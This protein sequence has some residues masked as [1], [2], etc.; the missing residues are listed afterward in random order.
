MSNRQVFWVAAVTAIVL[1]AVVGYLALDYGTNRGLR[2]WPGE[3]PPVVAD[4]QDDVSYRY[5]K[6]YLCLTPGGVEVRNWL[7]YDR[8]VKPQLSYD[9]YNIDDRTEGALI[10]V[11]DN[12]ALSSGHVRFHKKR[13]SIGQGPTLE[14]KTYSRTLLDGRPVQLDKDVL[15]VE[16]NGPLESQR[17][18]LPQ[19]GEPRR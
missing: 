19:C 6:T 5:T 11:T 7:F 15:L 1:S 4:A 9:Q 14:G 12:P 16:Y 13:V 8:W 3:K 18:P 17:R 10:K 2:R